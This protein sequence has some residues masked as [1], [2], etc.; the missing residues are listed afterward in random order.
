MESW[1]QPLMAFMGAVALL[2]LA[3]MRRGLGKLYAHLEDRHLH[4]HCDQE[5]IFLTKGTK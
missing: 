3:D 1:F 5:H 2:I 4:T